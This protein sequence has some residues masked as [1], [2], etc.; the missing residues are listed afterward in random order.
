MGIDFRGLHFELT[1]FGAGRRGCPGITFAE[2]VDELAL[3]KLVHK[4]D[5]RLSNGPK[6]KELDASE[7]SG[8]TIHKKCP[9]IVVANPHDC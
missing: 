8:I 4:F 5:F 7:S 2:V 1:P 6:M 3:A 9:L